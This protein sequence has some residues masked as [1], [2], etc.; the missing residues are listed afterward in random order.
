[1][2]GPFPQTKFLAS[3]PFPVLFSTLPQN[4]GFLS[5][6]IKHLERPMWKTTQTNSHPN[7]ANPFLKW[8]LHHMETHV[9]CQV[10]SAHRKECS[11][12]APC[13]CLE[14]ATIVDRY[15]VF[16]TNAPKSAITT[17]QNEEPPKHPISLAPIIPILSSYLQVPCPRCSPWTTWPRAASWCY[18]AALGRRWSASPP[19]AAWGAAP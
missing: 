11:P 17:L 12:I 18:P 4:P 6:N 1:M 3:P 13:I 14:L 19:A 10:S 16:C 15:V 8:P 2:S 9:S 7:C 5:P